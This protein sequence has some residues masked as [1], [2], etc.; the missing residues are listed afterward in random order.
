MTHAYAHCPTYTRTGRADGSKRP[1]DGPKRAVLAATA[2]GGRWLPSAAHVHAAADA[3]ADAAAA[4]AA[5]DA[6]AA[7]AAATAAE[8]QFGSKNVV[9]P[10]LS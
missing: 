4:T 6:A 2:A 8:N 7:T 5:A 9:F 10:L 1:S 3:A